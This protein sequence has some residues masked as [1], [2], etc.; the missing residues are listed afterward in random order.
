MSVA[1][2]RKKV[3]N[4]LRVDPHAGYVQRVEK[5]KGNLPRNFRNIVYQHYPEYNSEDGRELINNVLALRTVCTR[6]TEILERIEK[7]E[8]QLRPVMVE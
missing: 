1:G 3:S 6:L 7:R 4:P 2:K 5:I 8:L